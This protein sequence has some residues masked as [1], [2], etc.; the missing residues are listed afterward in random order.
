MAIGGLWVAQLALFTIGWL[1]PWRDAPALHTNG[2][3]ARPIRMAL[4]VSLVLAA[5]WIWASSDARAAYARYV[6]FGM[7]ASCVGDLIMARL[8]PLPNRLIGGM[9]T[10][11]LAHVLYVAA[12]MRTQWLNGGTVANPGLCIGRIFY[13]TATW[14]GWYLFI[15]NP[16]KEPQLN[17]GALVYGA[18]VGGMAACA[19]GLAW[20]LGGA[21]WL[22]ALGGL[23]FVASDFLIGLTDIGGAHLRNANDW[24]WLTYVAGQMGIIYA[25]WVSQ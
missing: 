9:V 7:S 11:G 22:T 16:D 17:A 23:V 5:Y 1:G 15:R 4:S 20:A 19:V 24:I 6:F 3:V 25:G 12:Y 10:F 18:W 8:L 13:G 21:W 2:R 14:A